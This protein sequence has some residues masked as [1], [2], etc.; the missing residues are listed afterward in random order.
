MRVSSLE[1]HNLLRFF[2]TSNLPLSIQGG[3]GSSL[4]LALAPND[5]GKT[6]VMRALEFLFYG[7]VEGK[8]G[9]TTLAALVNDEAVRSSKQASVGGYVEAVLVSHGTDLAVRRSLLV[10]RKASG[11]RRLADHQLHYLDGPEGRQKW[12]AD[13]E[14]VIAHKLERLM[15][16][17]LFNYFFFQGEGLADALIEKQDPKIKEGLTELLHEDDWQAAIDDLDSL[18]RKLTSE[19]REASGKNEDLDRA[20]ER[21]ASA[22][23]RETKL[24]RE[25]ERGEEQFGLAKAE[26][27]RL[28][29]EVAQSV[30]KI[31]EEAGRRLLQTQAKLKQHNQDLNAARQGLFS[32]IGG[33]RGLPFMKK[34]FQPVRD[35]LAD[36][37]DQNLLP[38]DVSEG[39][40]GRVLEKG[41][42][43]CGCDLSDGTVHRTNVEKFRAYSL[44]AELNTD[45]FQ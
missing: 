11:E 17:S 3:N 29:V 34:A 20:V 18:L 6:S 30:G 9:D 33:T 1:F 21:L 32:G 39:F 22:E 24:R 43:M 13:A 41:T 19:C 36:L 2:G 40:I 15:P 38:A 25:L 16:R 8:S 42:C 5:S 12:R 35:I 28:T 14:G 44:S 23:E 4:A 27:D 37:R 31:D 45:L 10:E 26:V 7:E